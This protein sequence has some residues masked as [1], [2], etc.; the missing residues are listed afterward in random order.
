MAWVCVCVLAWRPRLRV[1][2]VARH[3]RRAR[4]R[5]S[6]LLAAG[7]WP[8]LAGTPSRCSY[9]WFTLRLSTGHVCMHCYDIC[10][11]SD[12]LSLGYVCSV[13]A[14]VPVSKAKAKAKAKLDI[15]VVD[16]GF[17]ALGHSSRWLGRAGAH[18]CGVVP[19]PPP[20]SRTKDAFFQEGR[21]ERRI[22]DPP[23]SAFAPGPGQ[24]CVGI[25]LGRPYEGSLE[26]PVPVDPD[27]DSLASGQSCIAIDGSVI[28]AGWRSLG[29]G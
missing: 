2:S 5:D 7:R 27:S 4:A 13:A 21:R 22:R 6:L 3:V 26:M 25:G 20:P 12:G 23:E 18:A 24:H 10:E 9:L 28:S 17:G 14:T 19:L 15:H 16:S 1:D 11:S 29:R 8:P